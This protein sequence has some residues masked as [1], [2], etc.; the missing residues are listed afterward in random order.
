[1][2]GRSGPASRNRTGGLAVEQDTSI[3][4]RRFGTN[5]ML[6]FPGRAAPGFWMAQNDRSSAQRTSE[7]ASR[8]EGKSERPFGDGCDRDERR[9]SGRANAARERPARIFE[10]RPAMV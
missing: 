6:E 9:A 3:L 7:C 1:M 10:K 8:G 5:G 2:D 4:S